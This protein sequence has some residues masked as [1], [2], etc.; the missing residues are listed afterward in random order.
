ME[1]FQL[2]GH[3]PQP[4]KPNLHVPSTDAGF[5]AFSLIVFEWA[6]Q[7]TV[8]EISILLVDQCW[9]RAGIHPS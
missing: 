8:E 2:T 4:S 1:G 5:S 3:C 6:L 9:V 7:G